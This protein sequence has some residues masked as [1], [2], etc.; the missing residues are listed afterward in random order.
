[1]ICEESPQIGEDRLTNVE[2]RRWKVG[3]RLW[4]VMDY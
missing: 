2:I 3:K 1:V 4:G